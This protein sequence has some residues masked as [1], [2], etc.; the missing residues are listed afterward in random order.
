MIFQEKYIKKIFVNIHFI[1]GIHWIKGII[2]FSLTTS[3]CFD[4]NLFRKDEL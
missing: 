4:C 2:L 3:S 1:T